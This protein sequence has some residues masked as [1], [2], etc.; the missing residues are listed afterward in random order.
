MYIFCACKKIK[1]MKTGF[2]DRGRNCKAKPVP[3]SRTN[4]QELCRNQKNSKKLAHCTADLALN[5]TQSV[6]WYRI[7]CLCRSTEERRNS[8][9]LQ[10]V[11]LIIVITIF[12]TKETNMSACK[13]VLVRIFMNYYFKLSPRN[14]PNRT[15][16]FLKSLLLLTRL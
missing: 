9:P 15:I 2:S 14:P 11:I 4:I 12:K 1:T 5:K 16:V 7:R 8:S 10:S 3:T 6:R 13:L